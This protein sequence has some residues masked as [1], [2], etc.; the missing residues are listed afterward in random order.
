[1]KYPYTLPLSAALIS[2][3]A[4]LPANAELTVTPYGSLR[5]QAEAV[6]VDEAQPGEDD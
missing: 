1:M 2:G 4:A 3:M 6:S 5:I